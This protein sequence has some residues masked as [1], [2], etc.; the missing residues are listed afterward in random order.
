MH[1]DEITGKAYDS[2]LMKRLLSYAK[3]YTRLIVIGIC[4]TL[5]SSFLQLA[6]PLLTKIAIDDYIKVNDYEG[7]YFILI[8]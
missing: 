8:I 3:P 7:L 5:L 1:D 6:G 2:V 4:L